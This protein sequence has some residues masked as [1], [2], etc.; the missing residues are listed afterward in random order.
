MI[1]EGL[2][3]GSKQKSVAL[4]IRILTL[5]DVT[6]S[7][8]INA[9]ILKLIKISKILKVDLRQSIP[10]STTSKHFGSKL[11]GTELYTNLSKDLGPLL[12]CTVSPR[13]KR[14]DILANYNIHRT[15]LLPYDIQNQSMLQAKLIK[16][17]S[18]SPDISNRGKGMT[19]RAF[20]TLEYKV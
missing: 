11:N 4:L 5:H 3:Y 15:L 6:G 13:R 20:L 8:S 14:F 18:S 16:H 9:T 2:Q 12:F 19:F 1:C 10:N 7:K 17:F